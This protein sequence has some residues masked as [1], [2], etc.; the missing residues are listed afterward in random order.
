MRN[1]QFVGARVSYGRVL[2]FVLILFFWVF[3]SLSP[4][5]VAKTGGYRGPQVHE[6][7]TKT[8]E[9]PV[10]AFES[11]SDVVGRYKG[12]L[13]GLPNPPSELAIVTKSK[14]RVIYTAK[15][16]HVPTLFNYMKKMQLPL[17][18][19][20]VHM[21]LHGYAQPGGYI[22]G[23]SSGTSPGDQEREKALVFEE[24][25]IFSRFGLY[26][27]VT[28]FHSLLSPV[29]FSVASVGGKDREIRVSQFVDRDIEMFF[30]G[31]MQRAG[32]DG[33]IKDSKDNFYFVLKLVLRSQ[34]PVL[35]HCHGGDHQSALMTLGIRMIQGG[36]WT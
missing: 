16:P 12:L 26:P 27:E 6:E 24:S 19:V 10:E 23:I 1:Y 11:F 14:N 20:V 29:Y 18:N 15:T 5:M 9:P 30:R 25:K 3:L 21:D 8:A 31:K 22:S 35:I 32:V 2:G 4:V 28:F 17:P 13:S 34:D 7:E 33:S 36:E